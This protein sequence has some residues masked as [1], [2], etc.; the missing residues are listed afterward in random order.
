MNKKKKKSKV[1]LPMKEAGSR[2]T[3]ESECY[4]GIQDP[5]WHPET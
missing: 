5:V 1:I 2:E 4:I 3:K